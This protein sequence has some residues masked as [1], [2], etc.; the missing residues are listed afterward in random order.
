MST[1]GDATSG[2][3]RW[4]HLLAVLSSSAAA[5]VTLIAAGLAACWLLSVWPCQSDL[6]KQFVFARRGPSCGMS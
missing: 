1:D 5:G 2:G 3:S 4:Q 6:A